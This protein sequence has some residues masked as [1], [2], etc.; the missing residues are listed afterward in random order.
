MLGSRKVPWCRCSDGE[1]MKWPVAAA[2]KLAGGG[3]SADFEIG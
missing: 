3:E 2:C 1:G